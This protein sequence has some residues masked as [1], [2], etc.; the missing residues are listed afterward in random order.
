MSFGI[1]LGGGGAKGLAH[2][3]ILEVLEE[4]N[5]RPRFVAGTSI[6][7]VV[8]ALY[9]LQGSAKGLRERAKQMVASDEFKNLELDKFYTDAENIFE[10]FRNELFEKFFL[11][12]LLFKKSHSK[13]DATE[14]LYRDMFGDKSFK[15]CVITFA[16]NALDIQSGEEVV[17]EHGPLA[18]A[19]WASCAIPGIFPPFVKGERIFVD[20]GVIDNIP[21]EP[22]RSIGAESVLAVYLSKPPRYEG[23]PN[24]G[25]QINQRSYTFMKYH[26][27]QRVLAEADLVIEPEVAGFHWAD[28]SSID[29]L[30][31]RGRTAAIHKIDAVKSIGTRRYGLK[32]ILSRVFGARSLPR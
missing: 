1:A 14:K 11:G 19:V 21:I 13:Y 29:A 20:G 32:R 31:E 16:C 8:G 26:L 18:D 12:S 15:D 10:R 22:V 27:D 6:G 25:F 24:T 2:V 4:H 5:I 7:S 28:F 17:F 3:G 30:I 23:I 9:C